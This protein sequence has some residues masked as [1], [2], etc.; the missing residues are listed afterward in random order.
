M[1]RFDDR[2]GDRF[3]DRRGGDRD[4]CPAPPS[5][6]RDWGALRNRAG[7]PARDDRDDRRGGFR[8]DRDRSPSP[9]RDWGNIRNR[10]GPRPATSATSA[11]PARGARDAAGDRWGKSDAP[12]R[13]RDNRDR[14]DRDRGGRPRLVLKARSK[15][16][17][18]NSAGGG[19]GGLFGG[20]RPARRRA[21]EAGRDSSRRTSR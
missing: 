21:S 19:G 3:D 11:G 4:R 20:A 9:E 12:L 14:D 17:P 16:A 6:E 10:P 1:S 8:D 13:D 2:R 18:V 15:D 7:P 5:P